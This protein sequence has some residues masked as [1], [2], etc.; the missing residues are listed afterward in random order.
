[1][2]AQQVVDSEKLDVA[3]DKDSPADDMKGALSTELPAEK[4][5]ESAAEIVDALLQ[6]TQ[7]SKEKLEEYHYHWY[8]SQPK[9]V[10]HQLEASGKEYMQRKD[11][12]SRCNSLALR[13]QDKTASGYLGAVEKMGK[14][15][16]PFICSKL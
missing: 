11:D 4:V 3:I 13:L 14:Q 15:D 9:I 2:D 12:A 6:G 8:S 1:M 7:R 5:E 10:W 16:F